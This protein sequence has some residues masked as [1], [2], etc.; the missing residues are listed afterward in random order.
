MKVTNI[1]SIILVLCLTLVGCDY[2]D[3][4]PEKKGTLE[5]A[6]SNV[7]QARNFLYSCY[8]F[9][10]ASNDFNGEPQ[11]L[12]ASDEACLTSQWATNWHFSKIANLGQQTAA[13][14]IY[15]YW[16]YFKSSSQPDRCRSYN[17]YGA[18]RQ[19]YTFLKRIGSVPGID[20]TT[21]DS[22]SAE[23]NFLIAYYHYILLR[24]YG[25]IVLADREYPLDSPSEV[26]YPKR[27]PYD[28]CVNWIVKRLDD[29][30]NQL[31]LAPEAL[32]KPSKSAAKAIKAR[33]LLYAA[34]PLF[35]GN[36]EYYSNF[37]NKD[38]ELLM[39]QQYDKEKWKLAM[40]AAEE[41][42]NIAKQAGFDLFEY[43]A[44][45]DATEFEKAYYNHRWMNIRMPSEGN[46][47]LI[48][49]YSGAE[50]NFQQMIGMKGLCTQSTSVPYGGIAPSML[51]VESF[52]T[53]NGLP[54]DVDPQYLY[55]QRHEIVTDP[56]SGEKTVRLHLDR[57]PRFYADIAYDRSTNYEIG[58][59]N[60]VDK[61]GYKL[62]MRM[63]EVNPETK[64]SNTNDPLKDNITPNGYMWKKFLHPESTFNNN[65]IV[66]K[67]T[68]MPLIRMTELYLNYAEAYY[69]Y[70]GTLSGKALDYINLLRKRAGIPDVETSWRG[71]PGKDYREIIRRERTLELMF[72]GHRYFDAR[73]WKIAHLTFTK[74]QKRW[75][76]FPTGY[77]TSKPQPAEDYLTLKDSNEPTKTFNVPQHYL[78]PFDA[79]DIDTNP[80]LVQNPNW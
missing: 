32:G 8:S 28:E 19:C 34:S 18:I 42:I 56:V 57:E 37:K 68:V 72:E 48:W 22:W 53:K 17:L 35:N 45:A 38:G 20:Q 40:D 67:K 41:A 31:P 12:G 16:S 47:D 6:F 21:V 46:K 78:Y 59:R 52:L 77:T 51:M 26:A 62:Y 33:I 75:N 1:F 14:P 23:A 11:L 54:I 13:E 2:L 58:G 74:V 65:K 55:N 9:M 27:S 64:Q 25:P 50:I 39:S 30:G 73:R 43:P 70:N 79:R 36:S 61:K 66:L 69:E 44:P 60:G 15:N 24:L 76:C 63:G 71:I 80:N 5:E 10:P 29:A 49:A 4:D 3:Q 7:D